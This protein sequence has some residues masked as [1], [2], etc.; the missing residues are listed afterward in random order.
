[1]SRAL[2]GFRV[3]G[4]AYS[5]LN[6]PR[7]GGRLQRFKGVDWPLLIVSTLLGLILNQGLFVKGLSLTTAI[8]ATLLSTTIPASTFLIGMMLHTERGSWRRLLGLVI[9]A[10]GVFYLIG[11]GKTEFSSHT[12]VGDLM[13]VSNS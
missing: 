8:N 12:R 3:T 6:L 4:A 7:I 2:V 10:T 1:S 11:P 13:I 9:A 5:L